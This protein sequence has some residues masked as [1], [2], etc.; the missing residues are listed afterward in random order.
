[1]ETS[2]WILMNEPGIADIT[3]GF[4]FEERFLALFSFQK[5]GWLCDITIVCDDGSVDAHRVILAATSSYFKHM[6]SSA[7]KESTSDQI[8]MQGMDVESLSCIVKFLYTNDLDVTKENASDV[9]KAANLLCLP[10]V[11]E[12]CCKILLGPIS[13]ETAL[14]YA[15]LAEQYG[16][17][18]LLKT[19]IEYLVKYFKYFLFNGLYKL[20]IRAFQMVVAS[21][22]LD[23]KDEMMVFDTVVQWIEHDLSNRQQHFKSLLEHVRLPLL[24][25]K[26]LVDIVEKSRYVKTDFECRDLVDEAKNRHLLPKRT[27]GYL[28]ERMTPRKSTVGY[29]FL[30]GGLTIKERLLCSVERYDLP[31]QQSFKMP[32]MSLAR[33]G[34]GCAIL[35]KVLYVIGGHDGTKALKIGECM[36]FGKGSWTW[37]PQM[38]VPRRNLGVCADSSRIYAVGGQVDSNTTLDSLES[39]DPREGLWKKHAATMTRARKYASVAHLNNGLFVVGGNDGTHYLKCCERYDL[40]ADKWE[41]MA[42]LPHSF[43]ANGLAVWDNCLYTVGGFDSRQCLDVLYLYWPPSNTWTQLPDPMAHRRTGLGSVTAGH[44]LYA[45]GGHNGETYLDTV[46]MYDSDSRGWVKLPPLHYKRGAM[47]VSVLEN[48]YMTATD[49]L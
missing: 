25:P 19:S 49:P 35:E 37:V 26:Y 34:L 14:D 10:P 42:S 11:E 46:E 5:D 8:R 27:Q 15:V 21:D 32:D 40:R 36:D 33:S 28:S 43:G 44:N 13:K 4:C 23:V 12:Q 30:V 9:L 20:D 47:A 16:M 24:P 31:L 18:S 22:D 45:L 3:P 1:M 17:N 41:E 39:Y 7:M 6:F 2:Q 48:C 38:H 29:I